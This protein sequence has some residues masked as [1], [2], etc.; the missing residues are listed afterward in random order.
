MKTVA[1]IASCDTKYKEVEY[2]RQCFAGTVAK[3]LVVDMA[4]GLGASYGADITREEVARNAGENWENLKNRT[5]GELMEF[6]EGA[7][8][9]TVKKLY[10][11]GK[12]DGVLSIGGVQNTTVAARA[13]RALPIGF[14]TLVA[15]TVASGAKPF[16]NVVGDKDLA[17]IPSI[18]DFTG[19]NMITR[20]I[21]ANACAAM[22]GM[23]Q[24]AGRPLQKPAK[25]VVGITLMGVTNTGAIA[26]VEELERLGIEAVGFH[27][28]GVGGRIMEQLAQ[29]GLLDGILDLTTHEITSEYF[30]GGFS[31]GALNRLEKPAR[32]GI[33]LVVAP[34]GLD[35]VDFGV[36]NPPPRMDERVYNKHNAQLAHIKILP[37]EAKAI[38]KIFA[39]RVNLAQEGAVLLLPTNGMRLNTRPGENLY[40]K[41][42]DDALLQAICQN[43][44]PHIQVRQI[45]GN[46]NEKE[47][48][49]QAAHAMV[50]E[51]RRRGKIGGGHQ[52]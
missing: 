44:A 25:P 11:G 37:D 23:V 43:L 16:G 22:C 6:M 24:Y 50:D 5:K 10:D 31:Y 21:I 1:V 28:T 30:G 48:G 15:T 20:T 8:E 33:P 2:I 34:G 51:L 4:I 18:S 19:L 39:Q 12:I 35:F 3:P 46:L 17:V 9:T 45:V 49:V 13:M 38:G 26:A 36:D 27:S 29:D 52:Y 7:V 14:P 32:L 40:N 47:W 41:Q 42:T